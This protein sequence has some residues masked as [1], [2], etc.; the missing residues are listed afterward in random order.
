MKFSLDRDTFARVLKKI[1]GVCSS[2]GSFAILNSCMIEAK[3]NSIIVTGTDLDITLKAVENAHIIEEGT[4]I[5]NANRLLNTVQN[6]SQ[7]VEILLTS[8]MNQV[9]IEAGNFRARIPSGDIADFPAIP[10][11]ELNSAL[12]MSASTIKDLIDKTMFSISKDDSRPE[13]TGALLKISQN[14]NVE[15]VSTDGHRLS[16]ASASIN[17]SGEFPSIFE[18]GVIIPRKGLY[19]LTK[20]LFDS[21]VCLDI[22]G[23]KFIV[24]CGSTMFCINLIAGQFPDFSKVIPVKLD[25]KAVVKRDVFQQILKRASIFTA[26]ANTI[27]LTMNP[28]VLEVSTFDK[29]SGEMRDFIDAEYEGS[30]VT[31][32]FNWSY[33]S[34]ILSALDG[35]YVTLEI[36]DMDSP[37]VIRDVDTDKL[38]YIVMPMQL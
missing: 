27:R 7:G 36:I 11:F 3:G 32:G 13:F 37:A 16:R 28:G 22:S 26:K 31:A 10:T 17:I 4:V 24:N 23:T 2:R 25:H 30:G 9:L 18:T 8:E 19:E 20:N 5:I 12:T 1:D 15:M 34:E 21:Q 33:I 14:G 29:N 38:D 35:E 6:Q